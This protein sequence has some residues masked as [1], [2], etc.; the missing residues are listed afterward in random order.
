MLRI[1]FTIFLLTL[2]GLPGCGILS[3]STRHYLI[4]MGEPVQLA[5]SVEAL[6][7]IDG[8]KSDV[9]VTIPEGWWCLPDPG[10]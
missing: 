3:G 8:I 1:L 4:P 6:I 9:R 5:E 7:Y 10:E 2:V